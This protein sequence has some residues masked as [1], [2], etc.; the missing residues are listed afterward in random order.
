MLT[1]PG[2]LRPKVSAF[3]LMLTAFSTSV[4]AEEAVPLPGLLALEEGYDPGMVLVGA[5]PR[6]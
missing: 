6:L 1:S 4:A 2:S 3:V 5:Y